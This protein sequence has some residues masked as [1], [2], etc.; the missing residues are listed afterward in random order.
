MMTP[1]PCCQLG[2]ANAVDNIFASVPLYVMHS[3]LYTRIKQGRYKTHGLRFVF[4]EQFWAVCVLALLLGIISMQLSSLVSNAVALVK[5]SQHESP[6]KA[7][8]SP[9]SIS[10]LLRHDLPH[11]D[12]SDSNA[13]QA[14]L[15]KLLKGL[16]LLTY[17][18]LPCVHDR[19][20]MRLQ[21]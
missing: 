19:T 3:C 9:A 11:L 15:A 4:A 7:N 5:M 1:N 10:S 8:G 21:V 18:F 16:V 20:L 14:A 17:F 2:P 6:G 12:A 13:E